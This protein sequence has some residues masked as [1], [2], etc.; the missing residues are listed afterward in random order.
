MATMGNNG[1]LDT[2]PVSIEYPK[3]DNKDEQNSHNLHLEQLLCRLDAD[4]HSEVV[5]I[6][7]L[8]D[9]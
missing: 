7:Q 9:I 4:R 1:D 3:N 2:K 5:I 6:W 8:I